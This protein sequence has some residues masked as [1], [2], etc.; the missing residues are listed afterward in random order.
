VSA[1]GRP[2]APLHFTI[3]AL[4]V[5]HIDADQDASGALAG[6]MINANILGKAM[7]MAKYGRK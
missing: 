7:L 5:D 1:A 4:K 6:F 3:Y 2:A